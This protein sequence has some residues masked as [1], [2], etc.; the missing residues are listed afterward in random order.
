MLE[1]D[2]S[3]ESGSEW[4]ELDQTMNA[5]LDRLAREIRMKRLDPVKLQT[6]K[7]ARGLA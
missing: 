6:L 4:V 2:N 7:M 1:R 5:G 3:R